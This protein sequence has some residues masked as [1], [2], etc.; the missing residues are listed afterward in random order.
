M[1]ESIY[2]LLNDIDSSPESYPAAQATQ[3]AVKNWKKAFDKKRISSY[4]DRKN[5]WKTPLEKNMQ[6]PLPPQLSLSV[7]VPFRRSE[8]QLTLP[9][10]SVT[11]NLGQLPGDFRRSCPPYHHSSRG[12]RIQG[13]I[14]RNFK[15]K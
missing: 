7:P 14:H 4:S 9:V 5:H 11:Y 2:D 8:S 12:V 15:T 10:K 6:L 13:R 3:E 1:K